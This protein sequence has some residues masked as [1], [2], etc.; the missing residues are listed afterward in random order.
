MKRIWLVSVA[1]VCLWALLVPAL[2]LDDANSQRHPKDPNLFQFV[3]I[4]YNGYVGFWNSN[5]WGPPPWMHDYPRAEKNFLKIL[6]ELTSVETTPDSY[7]I[8]DFNDPEIMNYPILY[9]SEPGYWQIND[10]EI[11]NLRNYL[12]RGG[13][14]IFDDFRGEREWNNLTSAMKRVFPDRNF[15]K[16]TL[17]HP[18]FHCFYD[19]E[20]LEMRPP[21]NV[22]GQPTFYGLFDEEEQLQA[23]ANF[24]NDIGDYWEWSDDSFTPVNLSNEAF[25][26]GIN[27]IIYGMTH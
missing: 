20:T 14:M 17:D 11:T 26:F 12:T 8:L 3:R 2:S 1:W 4:R 25:K 7:L 5:R 9:V 16:L 27:Y 22:P 15:R 23:V 21:Y 19:I 24:N 13:F 18:V 6:M 10:Q